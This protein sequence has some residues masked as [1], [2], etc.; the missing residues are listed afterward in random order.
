MLD[1]QGSVVALFDQNG[2]LV[3]DYTYDAWGAP[4]TAHEDSGIHQPLRYRGYW[5]DGWDDSAGSWNSG[6]LPWYWLTTRYYDAALTRFL[7][8]DPSSRDGVRSY[9]YCHDDPVDCADP[10]G[11]AGV[12]PNPETGLM[13]AAG[14]EFRVGQT[15][16]VNAESGATED[17]A[18]LTSSDIGT[19]DNAAT[20]DGATTND[21]TTST[22]RRKTFRRKRRR[23]AGP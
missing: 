21:S 17:A 3:C 6:P 4:L 8:P 19:S 14:L 12:E 23:D 1:G 13:E 11:L 16:D 2:T 18:A 9:V 20:P 15:L 5:Y 10:S 22:V 7:Q